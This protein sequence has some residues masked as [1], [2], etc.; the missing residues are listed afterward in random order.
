MKTLNE[1]LLSK[2]NKIAKSSEFYCPITSKFNTDI[3]DKVT[4]VYE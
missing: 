3:L 1:Y 2:T 4:D